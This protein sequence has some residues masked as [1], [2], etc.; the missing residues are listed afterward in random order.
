MRGKKSAAA[1]AAVLRAH[2]R[3]ARMQR[4]RTRTRTALRLPEHSRGC[5]QDSLQQI[6]RASKASQRA[7]TCTTAGLQPADEQAHRLNF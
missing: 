5:Q 2:L 7:W 6:W 3:T 4:A 1:A